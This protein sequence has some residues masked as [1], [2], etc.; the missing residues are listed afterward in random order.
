M[1]L[2]R[3]DGPDVGHDGGMVEQLLEEGVGFEDVE[4][5]YIVL[6]DLGDAAV[7]LVLFVEASTALHDLFEAL[8]QPG[9]V[10]GVEKV[11]QHEIAVG[12]EEGKFF[13]PGLVAGRHGLCSLE[14][15]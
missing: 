8:G 2:V 7:G 13:G 15:L 5:A 12:A 4:D 11:L 9:Y 1:G 3:E 14:Y 6:V 10:V